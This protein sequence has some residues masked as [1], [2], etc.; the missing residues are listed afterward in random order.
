M[1]IAFQILNSWEENAEAWIQALEKSDILSRKITNQAI[2]VAIQSHL[3]ASVLDLGCGEGWLCR[4]LMES[5][6]DAYGVD[7]TAKLIETAKK[8]GNKGSFARLTFQELTEWFHSKL[9]SELLGNLAK[10]PKDGAVF[11][12]CL[13]EKEGLKELL[14]AAAKLIKPKGKI[15]IQTIHP[16]TM[17]L[18]ELPY[19]SQWMEDAWIGLKGEFRNGHPWYFR[20]F[21]DWI[22]EFTT[23]GLKVENIYEPTAPMAKNPSSVIFV[24]SM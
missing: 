19:Q 24:L 14:M 21:E 9:E 5:G 12:F 10:S 6:Y 23:S 13:Y 2:L 11:N 22:S 20:T 15:L 1:N 18:L 8:K 3:S 4:A 16:F 7:A 17:Q